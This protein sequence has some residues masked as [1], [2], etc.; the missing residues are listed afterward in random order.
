MTEFTDNIY[1][2]LWF[3]SETFDIINMTN[4]NRISSGRNRLN[5]GLVY[6]PQSIDYQ[7][8]IATESGL[9]EKIKH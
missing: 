6:Q 9:E 2:N 3:N 4:R 8:C 5:G 1:R 7:L